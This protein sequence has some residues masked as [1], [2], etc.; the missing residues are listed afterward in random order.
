[1]AEGKVVLLAAPARRLAA[2]RV[3]RA[4]VAAGLTQEQAARA[5]GLSE[6]SYRDIE[7]GRVRMAALE[8]LCVLEQRNSNSQRGVASGQDM[9]GAAL[10]RS[11]TAAVPPAQQWERGQ[12]DSSGVV[13]PTGGLVQTLGEQQAPVAKQVEAPAVARRLLVDAGSN[14]VGGLPQ[15]TTR[16][17]AA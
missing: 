3:R 14:P 11:D 17:R 10:I 7:L 5:A 8:A 4:R 9:S 2:A 12:A 6:R 13:R 1:M 16:R 15:E